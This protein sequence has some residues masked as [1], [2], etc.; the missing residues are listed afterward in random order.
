MAS[1]PILTNAMPLRAIGVRRIANRGGL[2]GG[3]GAQAESAPSRRVTRKIL[4]LHG[5]FSLRFSRSRDTFVVCSD[6]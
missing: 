1:N 5:R 6:I 3:K 2:D 4:L